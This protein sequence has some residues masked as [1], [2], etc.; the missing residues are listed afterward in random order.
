MREPQVMKKSQS[1]RDICNPMNIM[2]TIN[3]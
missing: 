2:N 3:G 1:V